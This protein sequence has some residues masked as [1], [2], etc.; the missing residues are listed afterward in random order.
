MARTQNNI[1]LFHD[2][3]FKLVIFY[4]NL[5][6]GKIVIN[7][8]AKNVKDYL[9]SKRCRFGDILYRLER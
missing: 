3:R 5:I 8:L 2:D 7:G 9:N 6:Y 1:N 4:Y